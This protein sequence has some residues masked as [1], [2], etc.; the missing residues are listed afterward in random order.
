MSEE[1]YLDI[2]KKVYADHNGPDRILEAWVIG[3]L[4][5]YDPVV[6]Y[7]FTKELERKGARLAESI[8]ADAEYSGKDP[9]TVNY[10]PI[11]QDFTRG[12]NYVTWQTDQF[13]ITVEDKTV[14]RA[15]KDNGYKKIKWHT[16][17]DEK[18]CKECEER[19]GK[20]Y[21]IDKIPTKH[22]NCRCYF[23]PEKA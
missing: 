17:D 14:I 21:P 1:A 15:F 6:K 10:P 23:T 4:D 9:P 3:I 18:V 5:D 2:A 11:K 12:L 16:Q 13:A 20:I 19:N 8:I 22:P 7:V